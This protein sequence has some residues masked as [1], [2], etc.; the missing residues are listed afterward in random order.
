MI[1]FYF[2]KKQSEHTRLITN[3]YNSYTGQ[4][5]IEPTTNF[6]RNA[7]INYKASALF[8][9][10]I[11]R[12]EGLIYKW[13]VGNK[14][15]FFYLDHAYLGRGYNVNDSDNEWMRITDSDFT[16]NKF[17]SRPSDRWDCFFK[18]NYPLEPWNVHKGENILILPPSL[19]TKFLFPESEKWLTQ[20]ISLIG[21]Y[22][23]K[24]IVVREKP[25]QMNI[26]SNNQI[27]EK[28]KY[29]YEKNIYAELK[30][31][32][33]VITYNSAV[34]VEATIL[35]IP[36]ITSPK[37]AAYPVSLSVENIEQINQEP[38]RQEW[39]HQLVYHQYNT[40]EMIDGSIWPLLLNGNKKI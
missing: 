25:L 7:R 15:R 18:K 28:V 4:K 9:A 35:G 37:A 23:N 14:K 26:F 1:V 5:L 21:Q 22:T 29:N 10:G 27:V 2:N 33:C 17:E 6:Q 16:W 12:G 13:C 3:L 31:A 36:V 38:K 8:F 19:A 39:L 11:I 20:T 24:N 30:D 40:R 34:P 32:H